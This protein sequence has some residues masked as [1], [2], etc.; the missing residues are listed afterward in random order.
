MFEIKDLTFEKVAPPIIYIMFS[1]GFLGHLLEATRDLMLTITPPFLFLM[2][3]FVLIP[4]IR[5][6][7][8]KVL[9]WALVIYAI[10]F[11]IEVLGV[12]TGSVFG[13]YE[14][15]PTLGL[16]L[17]AVPVVIGFNWTLVI[18]GSVKAS[19]LMTRNVILVSLLSG[20]VAFLFDYIL[21]PVAIHFDY[22]TW[23]VGYIPIQNYIAW[24]VI[25]SIMALSFGLLKLRTKNDL[26][27]H[28][29]VAQAVFFL[30]I[31]IFIVGH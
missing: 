29:L 27:I 30:M 20:A 13:A 12:E 22:W 25:A 19:R 23:D 6:R 28:Y 10:T 21:E 26:L 11:S 5:E 1:V 9:V 7:N 18:L 31:R 14:Y 2:G 4:T 24:F 17:F 15:G 8:W 16:S 3:I